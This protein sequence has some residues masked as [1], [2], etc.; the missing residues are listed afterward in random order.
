M[1]ELTSFAYRPGATTLHRLDARWKLAGLIALSLASLTAGFPLLAVFS[2]VL[3]LALFS[4][5]LPLGAAAREL[6]WFAVLLIFVFVSRALTEPGPVVFKI[7]F[8]EITASGLHDGLL[9]CWRLLFVAL[10]GL[11]LVVSTRPGQIRRAVAWFLRPI[12]FVPHDRVAA[13]LSLMVRFIPLIFDEYKKTAE[14]QK[15]R[16]VENRKNPIYR[17]TRLAVP[18]LR[19]IFLDAD[20]LALAM[21]ARCYDDE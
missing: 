5:K 9:V 14:A 1:A 20:K 12:P 7:G 6:K 19:R 16:G 15:A 3:A 11:V 17:M 21:E 18:L 8:L 4:L 2:L 13:M 10:L